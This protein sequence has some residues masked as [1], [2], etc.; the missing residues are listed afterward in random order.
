MTASD[1][2][3]AVEV[4]ARGLSCPL[5]VVELARAVS[6]HPTGTRFRLVSTD[7]GARVDIPVWCRMKRQ[8]LVTSDE[9][10]GEY[11]FVVEKTGDI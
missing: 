1:A 10:D 7:V 2:D 8:T 4:D 9:Q 5:P 3:G 6:Q 11:V